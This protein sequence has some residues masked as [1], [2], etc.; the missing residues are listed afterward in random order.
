[1]KKNFYQLGFFAFGNL[2]LNLTGITLIVL[3]LV[4]LWCNLT[5][6]NYSKLEKLGV[7][8]MLLS[9]L[10]LVVYSFFCNAQNK[11]VFHNHQILITGQLGKDDGGIYTAIYQY[12]D[13]IDMRDIRDVKLV[14]A[15]ADSNKKVKRYAGKG[16]LR[17]MLY[18]EFVLGDG[19]TKWMWITP[20]AR[21][22]RKK[23]LSIINSE[24]GLNLAYDQLE[25][26][27][28]SIFKRKKQ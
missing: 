24:T 8:I 20:F 2:I 27:D 26:Y 15:N 6:E 11:I 16:S 22:Q 10:V 17:P 3:A 14:F 23:M 18:F 28:Y 9:L 19:M 25:E 13:K 12:K 7:S 21:S 4:G 1:M 5:T